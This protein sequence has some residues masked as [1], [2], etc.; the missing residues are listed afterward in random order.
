MPSPTSAASFKINAS[1]I[2]EVAQCT[3]SLNRQL[4]DTTSLGSTY[5]THAVGFLEGSVQVETLFNV[6]DH[7]G[8]MTSLTS[9]TLLTGVELVW[10]TGCSIKGDGRVQDASV[11]VAPNGICS[12][13]FTIVFSG[14]AFTVDLTA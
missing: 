8:I 11:S 13:N 4:I 6:A 3:L 12:A 2:D 7:S 9:G 1:V 10:E 5:R 14:S